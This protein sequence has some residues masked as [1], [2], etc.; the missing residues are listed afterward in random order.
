ML[1]SDIQSDV[2]NL[3]LEWSPTNST[4][5]FTVLDVSTHGLFMDEYY[6]KLGELERYVLL[7]DSELNVGHLQNVRHVIENIM[8]RKYYKLLAENIR[9]KK[10]LETF[11]NTLS[12]AGK[13]YENKQVLI[14]RIRTLLPH[15]VHH[16]QTNPGGYDTN[17]IGATDVRRIIGDALSVLQDL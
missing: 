6:R 13:P 17:A 9:D 16:D 10:S 15:E 8:K 5:D 12:E 4:S 1:V 7:P 2:V 3:M 11:I 14:A